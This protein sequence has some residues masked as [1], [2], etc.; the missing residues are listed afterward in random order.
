[1]SGMNDNLT[2][3]TS[4]YLSRFSVKQRLF[5]F[6]GTSLVML[7]V[8]LISQLFCSNSIEMALREQ[9]KSLELSSSVNERYEIAF[10]VV[11]NW[12]KNAL[13]QYERSQKSGK[14]ALNW[15]LKNSSVSKKTRQSISLLNH[16]I[17]SLFT[18]VF[19]KSEI[20]S[21]YVSLFNNH[22]NS[23]DQVVEEIK[24]KLENREADLQ[25]EGQR[26]SPQESEFLNVIRDGKILT[27][28][29]ITLLNQLQL[30][31]DTTIKKQFSMI[32]SSKISILNSF[33]SFAA[34]MNDTSYNNTAELF[35]SNFKSVLPL[36]D[37]LF[38]IQKT[39]IEI[40]NR[41]KNAGDQM[42][43]IS[44]SLLSQAEKKVNSAKSTSAMALVTIVSISLLLL[45]TLSLGLISSITSPIRNLVG[46][47]EALGKG[48]LSFSIIEN[49]NDEISQ[50]TKSLRATITNLRDMIG[51]LSNSTNSLNTHSEQTKL[52]AHEV[53]SLSEKQHL[54]TSLLND[55]ASVVVSNVKEIADTTADLSKA[56]N[57]IAASIEEMSV[58]ISEVTTTCLEES[59]I[60]IEADKSAQ[61]VQS[62]MDNLGNSA[63]QIGQVISVI[64]RIAGKT[65]LLA[66]N[67]S[68]EAAAAGKSGMGFTVVANE[69]KAL[70][71]Q[72]ST[73]TEDI[74]KHI[75]SIQTTTKDAINS[76]KVIVEIIHK[77]STYSAAI[78]NMVQEQKTTVN[79]ISLT[80]SNASRSAGKIAEN[81]L[82]SSKNMGEISVAIQDVDALSKQSGQVIKEINTVIYQLTGIGSDLNRMIHQFKL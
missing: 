74:Q 21:K 46:Y 32:V 51:T 40:V 78:V 13:S 15:L 67:A 49:G 38:S 53:S 24:L 7:A 29:T 5:I 41:F 79:E 47:V 43:S 12:D 54:K 30:K 80:M 22:I 11:S 72:T 33:I 66:L 75:H 76:I 64:K 57:N 82:N 34:M 61:I 50:I 1:M 69:V 28:T 62:K 2:I 55:S 4:R 3:K 42:S 39:Q 27:L 31:Q 17:D 37:T 56:V 36:V 20:E 19:T 6:G 63:E 14:N 65:N 9:E 48:D 77:I 8:V 16:S 44:E 58:S 10:T 60:A 23:S 26:L 45:A 71:Q 59:K 70:A 73:A 52:V 68:I 81:T 35:V 18:I 25:L